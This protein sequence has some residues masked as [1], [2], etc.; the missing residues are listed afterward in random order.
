MKKISVV[1]P[2]FNIEKYLPKCLFSI[3]EQT[4]FQSLEIIL[5]DDG[6]ND[7]SGKICDDFSAKYNNVKVIHKKN[8]GVSSARNA[9][10][11]IA[12]G[13]Y[14]SFVDGDD[15]L[16]NDHFYEMLK[17]IELTHADLIIHDYYVENDKMFYKYRKN[18]IFKKFNKHEAIKE[19]LS[20]G[21]IGNNL[22]DKSFS[23]QII[24]DIRFDCSI[25]IGEDLLFIYQAIENANNIICKSTATYHYI[26]RNGSAMNSNFSEKFFDILKVSKIIENRI[27]KNYPELINYSEALTIY[28]KYKT[29]ERAYKSKDYS[30]YLEE[31]KLLNQ[32]I[33]KFSMKTAINCLS[34]KKFLGLLLIKISPKLYLLVCK[35]KNI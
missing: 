17:D 18:N 10:I 12:K 6:S 19:I 9:G 31:I 14:V 24:K 33:K 1:I 21:I 20:G 27:K 26:Q 2:V 3:E 13:E 16:D 22:F 11:E 28:S 34:T 29:L 30:N 23:R 4:A 32:D 35:L 7:N 25:R 15:Y 5:V 8:G